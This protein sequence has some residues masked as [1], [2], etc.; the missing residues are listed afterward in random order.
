MTEEFLCVDCAERW[1]ILEHEESCNC[2]KKP[3]IIQYFPFVNGEGFIEFG[4]TYGCKY[5]VPC[6]EVE[7][8]K[9]TIS[10]DEIIELISLLINSVLEQAFHSSISRTHKEI[11][12]KNMFRAKVKLF[13]GIERW[14]R[15]A[16]PWV[17]AKRP[18]SEVESNEDNP[19][20]VR[21][22]CNYDFDENKIKSFV[23]IRHGWFDHDFYR[24]DVGKW[25][26]D[27]W[28][29]PDH[30]IGY[31][32]EVTHWMPIPPIGGENE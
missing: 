10:F 25:I 19:V 20:I 4:C 30:Y 26:W 21:I 27:G 8:H 17:S 9:T 12:D 24:K 1:A 31:A 23:I 2:G 3:F 13:E 5:L 7:Y 15:G 32:R 16:S 22:E 6:H 11:T 18:P 14:N 28:G 29:E